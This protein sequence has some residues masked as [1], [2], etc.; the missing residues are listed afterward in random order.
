MNNWWKTRWR[1]WTCQ[2]RVGLRILSTLVSRTNNRSPV[3]EDGVKVMEIMTDALS[4]AKLGQ[5]ISVEE[6]YQI[7][8]LQAEPV[9]GW[10]I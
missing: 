7:E 8:G 4:S 10:P 1:F 5:E 6:L 2:P 3:G 9:P